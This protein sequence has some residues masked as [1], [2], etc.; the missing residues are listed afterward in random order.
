MLAFS[1]C[2]CVGF[3]IP[4]LLI[5]ALLLHLGFPL[6]FPFPLPAP[7]SAVSLMI[8]S[9]LSFA[10]VEGGFGVGGFALCGGGD[11]QTVFPE[12]CIDVP[13]SPG[14]P[15]RC[16]NHRSPKAP[17]FLLVVIPPHSS[18]EHGRP[19]DLSRFHSSNVNFGPFDISTTS[20]FLSVTPLLSRGSLLLPPRL[21]VPPAP[22]RI[23]AP[24]VSGDSNS[25]LLTIANRH[26]ASTSI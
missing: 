15:P 7:L 14:D 24:V 23:H 8:S 20:R 16:V 9:L 6:S 25:I 5:P 12:V 19:H 4:L 17:H 10:Y 11:A 26:F 18:L 3:L 21:A 22:Q 2:L 1:P 13:A